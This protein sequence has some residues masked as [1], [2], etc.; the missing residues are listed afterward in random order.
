MKKPVAESCQQ[1]RE[2]IFKVIKPLLESCQTVLEIGSGT[3]QHAVYF[4][5]QLAHLQWQTSDRAEYHQGINLW[6]EDA[7]HANIL[8]PL[9][10]DVSKDNW[11][12]DLFDAIFSANTLHIMS[13]FDVVCFFK[14][15]SRRLQTDGLLIIYGPFNYKGSYTSASNAQFDQWL[16]SQDINSGIKD[17][18]W[19]D[20]L[21]EMAGMKL[22]HDISMPANNRVLCWEKD[23]A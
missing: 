23:S 15:L 13:H 5:G 14:N 4:A 3:G 9:L 17:F 12:T 10:L 19:V 8:E 18:E 21:A 11:P 22:L 6:L 2:P 20:R 7:D 1:N 16:K